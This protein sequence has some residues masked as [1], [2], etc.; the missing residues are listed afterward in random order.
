MEYIRTVL[1]GF[2][3]SVTS[4][5]FFMVAMMCYY[6]SLRQFM[7]E[8]EWLG[9]HRETM[10]TRLGWLI[11]YGMIA[12]LMASMLLIFSGV[13]LN[14]K[15][16]YFIW[17]PVVLITLVSQRYSIIVYGAAIIGLIEIISGW[18]G[19]NPA[20]LLVMT[21]VFHMMQGFLVSIDGARDR[22]PV[23][24]K[25]FDINGKK[26]KRS[27]DQLKAAGAYFVSRLWPIPMVVW[28]LPNAYTLQSIPMEM[29]AWM[30]L[31]GG[32]IEGVPVL[33]P[34][35]AALGYKD[36]SL[37]G[38]PKKRAKSWGIKMLIYGASVYIMGFVSSL[39]PGLM[40]PSIILTAAA[41]TAILYY[42]NIDKNSKQ[43]VYL[44]PWRGL[45]VLEVVPESPADKM[46][47]EIGDILYRMNSRDVN[48]IEAVTN[49]LDDFPPH[50][51]LDIEREEEKIEVEY[52]D[53]VNGIAELGL[54]FVPRR[55]GKVFTMHKDSVL[56]YYIINRILKRKGR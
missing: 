54:I 55:I 51:W 13:T 25:E 30:Q 44:P 41:Y 14:Y 47:I 56:I 15:L 19:I 5:L 23:V 18:P 35:V 31:F 9:W 32:G 6:H 34:I 33:F 27:V 4:L 37:T 24:V 38:T 20:A 26:A 17:L 50:V 1:E 7:L 49:R 3:H 43:P 29:P 10:A 28:M 45:K 42:M 12:G 21:G 53:Y 2:L 46:G 52:K 48:S 8:D 36:L 39:I 11:L 40:L 16:V 22:V